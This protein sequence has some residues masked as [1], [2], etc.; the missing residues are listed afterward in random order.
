[1]QEQLEELSSHVQELHELQEELEEEVSQELWQSP[2]PMILQDALSSTLNY[3]EVKSGTYS[4]NYR[5]TENSDEMVGMEAC[6]PSALEAVQNKAWLQLPD[7]SRLDYVGYIASFDVFPDRIILRELHYSGSTNTMM[8]S[9]GSET[10]YEENYG[11]EL[12]KNRIYEVIAEWDEENLAV[13]G[14]Y[15]TAYYAFATGDINITEDFTG[16]FEVQVPLEVQDE[17][18]V[19]RQTTTSEFEIMPSE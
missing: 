5:S 3:F 16:A 18:Y 10:V 2:P 12:K 7:Y 13:N 14:F 17:S 11:L 9:T 19:E 15:G 4:W 6:G 8:L 1:M